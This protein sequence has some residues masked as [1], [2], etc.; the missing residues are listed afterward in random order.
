M[1]EAYQL[2]RQL[3]HEI[4]NAREN[5]DK[6][7]NEIKASILKKMPKL[8]ESTMEFL[9]ELDSLKYLNIDSDIS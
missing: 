7:K 1:D 8:N 9:H 4:A 5:A 2:I 3:D 6:R